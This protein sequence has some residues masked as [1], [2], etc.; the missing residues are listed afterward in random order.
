MTPLQPFPAW[1]PQ[2]WPL[3]VNHDALAFR[4]RHPAVVE[5]TKMLRVRNKNLLFPY[6]TIFW[7][8]E[9]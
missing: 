8:T 1:V 5:M 7:S 9:P 2:A 3:G 6:L 4:K